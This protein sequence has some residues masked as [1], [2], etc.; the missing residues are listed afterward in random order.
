MNEV[1]R[2]YLRKFV[3]VLFDE[4][5]VYSKDMDLHVQHLEVVFHALSSHQLHSNTKK[6]LFIQT[7]I[8]YLG[9][10][11]SARKVAADPSK[12]DAMLKGQQPRPS[13]NFGDF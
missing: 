6:C 9:H 7:K 5:L 3:L 11:V 8:E 13:R 4:I 1:F 12:I 2:T 10:L